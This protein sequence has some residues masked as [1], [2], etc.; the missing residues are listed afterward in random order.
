MQGK[1]YRKGP[2]SIPQMPLPSLA[3]PFG[4][5]SLGSL[6][7]VFSLFFPGSF[8]VSLISVSVPVSLHPALFPPPHLCF[9][10][11]FCIFSSSFCLSF[12][13]ESFC[14]FLCVSISLSACLF[15][16]FCTS[17]C[18]CVSLCV[19]IICHWGNRADSAYSSSLGKENSRILGSFGARRRSVPGPQA[20]AGRH[21]SFLPHYLFHSQSS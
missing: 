9:S 3:Q 12:H 14:S 13:S 20:L 2:S 17:V 7:C 16:A 5:R 11:Y 15:L 19:P 1:S 10:S 8:S 21:R 18:V 6:G 4:T